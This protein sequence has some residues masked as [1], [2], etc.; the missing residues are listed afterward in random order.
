ME[1][2]SLCLVIMV[3]VMLVQ[4]SY[5]TP[6]KEIYQLIERHAAIN[7]LRL[8]HDQTEEIEIKTLTDLREVE[9]VLS[10]IADYFQKKLPHLQ[11]SENVSTL[12]SC[13]QG[14][15]ALAQS[16][17]TGLI[18]SLDAF[19]KPGAGLLDGNF[20]AHGSF[21]EC[22]DIESVQ[23]CLLTLTFLITIPGIPDPIPLPI[24]EAVCIPQ[25]CTTDD[26]N[27]VLAE[28]Q[29]LLFL[30]NI[31]TY[32]T[33]PVCTTE[34]KLP[35]TTGAIMVIALCSFFLC[36]IAV[37]TLY[38]CLL[39]F[40]AYLTTHHVEGTAL[41]EEKTPLLPLSVNSDPSASSKASS[42]LGRLPRFLENT[43]RSFSLYKTLPAILSTKQPPSAITCING[44]RVISMFWVI[45]GHTNL[46]FVTSYT[47]S[48]SLLDKTIPSFAYQAVVNAFFSVDS[49]F[50]LS[51]LLTAY[52]T[53]REMSRS[54]GRF[55]YLPF[56]IHRYLR[57]T[58]TLAFLIFFSMYMTLH[59]SDG[60]NYQA[61]F[62]NYSLSYN[63][64]K[65][66]W[67]TN[68]LYINN[69]HP[70]SLGDECVGWTWYLANDMQ[71]YV[72]SP[73]MIIL[74]YHSFP[75]GLLSV[76]VFLVSC[77]AATGAIVGHYGYSA[78]IMELGQNTD[79]IYTKPYCRIFPYLVGLVLGY[80]IYKKIA[81]RFS[82]V[83]NV[84]LYLILWALAAVS[85]MSVVY[86]LYGTWHGHNLSTAESVTY[87]MFNRLT[88][89]IGLALIVFS[90]HN[91]Y[92]WVVN[93]FLSMGFWVP[94]SRLTFCTYLVHPIV[95][96]VI[97]A[98]LRQGFPFTAINIAVYTVASVL[99]SYG[100]AGVLAVCV[101]FPLGY[102]EMAT[103]ELFGMEVRS[104]PKVKPPQETK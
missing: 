52:L 104:R 84:L 24:T 81:F 67:W 33:P 36:L 87:F 99:F 62:N 71:F 30:A 92:G 61:S 57:L 27:W 79:A 94:L 70:S 34:R 103:F 46:F 72:V 102:V 73:L 60:P 86:G 48:L 1:R 40:K 98:S 3:L 2:C 51:G 101:E 37:S 77:L 4:S 38:D 83:L 25:S 5:A 18:R 100:V 22:M 90:C 63:T 85:C 64:C 88:W 19:G 45:L 10:T 43:L 49:F 74:L 82:K 39:L 11:G 47:N 20:A 35:L 65:S 78:S 8:T 75:L 29:T 58:P 26:M 7:G 96:T 41:K 59:L 53:L 9:V 16:S 50:F 76:G 89:G 13:M 28:I 93:S 91:G 80:V 21:D 54:N 32:P 15:I 68:L 12:A 44:L 6:S 97:Q 14:Y 42:M 66:Y 23:Y 55:P 69:F 31:I 17:P 56:Y 95:I